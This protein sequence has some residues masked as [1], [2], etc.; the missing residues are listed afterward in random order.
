M[1]RK[2]YEKTT[3]QQFKGRRVISLRK[4]RTGM[5]ELPPGMS[6]TIERKQGGFN[7]LSDPCPHC[8]IRA[9]MSK[10]RPQDVDFTDM[11]NIWP[12]RPY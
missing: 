12:E 7:L 10:V 6:W 1:D 5:F 8:G 3:E 2:T 4:M 9:Y 11:Q